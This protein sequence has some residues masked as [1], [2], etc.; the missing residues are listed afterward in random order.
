M[1]SNLSAL[2]SAAFY[3]PGYEHL[4]EL[5]HERSTDDARRLVSLD[6]GLHDSEG[7]Q[8]ADV[9]VDPRQEILDLGALVTEHAPGHRRVM[10]VFDAR[11]DARTFPYRPHHYAYVHRR[12]SSSPPLYYAVTASR[13]GVPDRMATQV[14]ILP[15]FESYLFLD[16]PVNERFSVLLGNLGHFAPG[17]AQLFAY[18]GDERIVRDVTLAPRAH[19]ELPLEPERNGRRLDRLELKAVFRL[20]GYIVGRRDDGDLVLFDHLFAYFT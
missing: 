11:F 12:G 16:R 2:G 7:K 14:H 20:S 19:V 13:G 1:S 18:Y 4:V 10:A 17:A 5:V 15:H 3:E 9:S 8:L 6:I